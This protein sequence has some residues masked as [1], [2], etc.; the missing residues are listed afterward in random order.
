MHSHPPG[1][2]SGWPDL[3]NLVGLALLGCTVRQNNV[4]SEE[5]GAKRSDPAAAAVANKVVS[6]AIACMLLGCMATVSGC[7]FA[8]GRTETR[9][10]GTSVTRF[11][12]YALFDSHN[13]LAKLAIRQTS[14]N[15]LS[16]SF[17]IG[18]LNQEASGSNVVNILAIGAD[19][20]LRILKP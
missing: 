11:R 7:A 4:S 19:G 13:E 10:D 2:W 3:V 8:S 6:V 17:G 18:S 9:A 15:K 16:Q 5:A 14:T 1:G 20:A 12:G